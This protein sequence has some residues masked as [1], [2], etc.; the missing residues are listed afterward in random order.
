MI[1]IPVL[2]I[3]I[4]IIAPIAGF[5]TVYQGFNL[6]GISSIDYCIDSLD[7]VVNNLN[8]VDIAVEE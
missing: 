3:V 1:F 6:R 4:L 8:R 7:N 5:M 2:L